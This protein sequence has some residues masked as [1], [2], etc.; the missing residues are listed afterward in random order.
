MFIE[1]DITMVNQGLLLLLFTMII[2]GTA[3]S[4]DII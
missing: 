1:S 2:Y 4:M 3:I